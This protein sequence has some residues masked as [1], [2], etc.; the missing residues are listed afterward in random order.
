VQLAMSRGGGQVDDASKGIADVC[1]TGPYNLINGYG[2]STGFRFGLP[3]TIS[4]DS[5]ELGDFT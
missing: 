5:V 1:G 4:S 2:S 3:S